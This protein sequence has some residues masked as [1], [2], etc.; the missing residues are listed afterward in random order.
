MFL[1]V[2]FS[3]EPK[4]RNGIYPAEIWFDAQTSFHPQNEKYFA[5]FFIPLYSFGA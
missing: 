5:Q 4:A 2:S 3:D 1:A